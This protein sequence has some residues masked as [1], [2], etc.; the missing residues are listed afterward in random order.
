MNTMDRITRT[1]VWIARITGTLLLAFLLFMLIGHLTGN[2]NG[3]NGMTFSSTSDILGFVLFPVCSIIGLALAYKWKLLGGTIAVVSM[4][5]LF[6]LR[7]DLM[8]ISF[9]AL[10]LPAL[11]YMLSGWLLMRNRRSTNI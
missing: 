3:P 9:I 1:L 10:A 11:L 6:A 2:A 8:R 5:A 4:L 7:P